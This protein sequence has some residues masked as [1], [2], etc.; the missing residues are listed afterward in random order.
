[1]SATTAAERAQL[2]SRRLDRICEAETTRHTPPL[3]PPARTRRLRSG[4]DVVRRNRDQPRL[5]PFTCRCAHASAAWP[6]RLSS[7]VPMCTCRIF[8]AALNAHTLSADGAAQ[9]SAMC[10]WRRRQA[11]RPQC[12]AFTDSIGRRRVFHRFHRPTPGSGQAPSCAEWSRARIRASGGGAP[13]SSRAATERISSNR[14]SARIPSARKLRRHAHS[15]FATKSS[16]SC[17]GTRERAST[18]AWISRAC[19]RASATKPT[20]GGVACAHFGRFE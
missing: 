1:M 2:A 12:R 19:A 18:V 8:P 11:V 3:R 15:A 9:R 5:S 6:K 4:G 13:A 7:C 14:S 16:E 17:C 20:V 10:A